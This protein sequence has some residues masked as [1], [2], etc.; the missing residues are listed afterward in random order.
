MVNGY[1]YQA[2]ANDHII[3]FYC[4]INTRW[5]GFSLPVYQSAIA[6]KDEWLNTLRWFSI[7]Q[8]IISFEINLYARNAH[9]HSVTGVV[10]CR[11]LFFGHPIW[12]HCLCRDDSFGI[13]YTIIFQHYFQVLFWFCR[14]CAIYLLRTTYCYLGVSKAV[15]NHFNFSAFCLYFL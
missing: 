5:C 12:S 6:H 2:G 1:C 15:F 8:I 14:C 10:F 11:I 4:A 13:T 9:I 7:S 3:N